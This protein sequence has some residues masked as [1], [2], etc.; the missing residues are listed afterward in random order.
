MPAGV[1]SHCGA[2]GW[3]I[4]G[5]EGSGRSGCIA[6][7]IFCGGLRQMANG[8]SQEVEKCKSGERRITGMGGAML[9]EQTHLGVS[10]VIPMYNEEDVITELHTRLTHVLQACKQEYE[11]IFVEDGSRDRTYERL[12]KVQEVDPHVKLIKLRG[13]F[14][15]TPA[16][17]AGFD[18]AEGDIIIAMDG[19]LQHAPED[20]PAFLD[21]LKEGYDVVSGWRRDRKDPYLS[22]KLP[23]RIAN[24]TMSKLSGIDLHDFGT[25]FKAY[26]RDLVKEI[27]LY[28]QFHRFIPV[29]ARRSRAKIVEIP[30]ENVR[31]LHRKSHYNIMRTF[32]VAFDLMRLN[33][34]DKFIERPLQV[35]G[36]LGAVIGTMGA[37]TFAYLVYVKYVYGLSLMGYRGPLF[38]VSLFSILLGV[39]FFSLGLLGEMIVKFYHDYGHTKIYSVGEIHSRRLDRVAHR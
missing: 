7:V 14:G 21:K 16:L 37:V 25:T 17:A 10:V 23:S 11:I 36:T 3:F 39:L 28:G 30:I 1:H 8:V 31:Q 27:R 12:K 26:K 20:I 29:L 18:Y 19:D 38:I 22:R 32:T 34:L 35:Y 13:N 15:Q 6:F 24:W 2:F 5:G 4:Y 33:Y 9:H